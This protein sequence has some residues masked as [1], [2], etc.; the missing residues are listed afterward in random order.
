[1]G[2]GKHMELNSTG[3]ESGTGSLFGY[4]A[5]VGVAPTSTVFTVGV[6][7]SS[8]ASSSPFIAYCFHSV[9]GYQKIGSYT[10]SGSSGKVVTT[11]FQPR[12]LMVKAAIRPSGGGSWY[13][14][15]NVRTTS[16]PQGQYLQ[17]NES[18]QEL[19]GTSVFNIDF[20]S[21]GFTVN[22]TNNEINQSG[23]TY[24]YLAIK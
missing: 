12:F 24:I 17:A 1:M 10:G 4:P 20:E 9:T 19:D 16:N 6:S 22:G 3:G 23:S 18:A 13:I 8:N 11:G 2:T 21:N 7:S 15:D 14:F 5:D